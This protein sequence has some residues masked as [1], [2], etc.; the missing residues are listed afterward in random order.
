MKKVLL[1]LA[2]FLTMVFSACDDDTASNNSN[3]TN[4]TN[5]NN[6]N[7]TNNTNTNTN[8]TNNTNTNNTNNTNTNNINN[9]NNTNND[10]YVS[11]AS[12]WGPG[13]LEVEVMGFDA[14]TFGSNV[15]FTVYA[16]AFGGRY[17]VI[18]FQHGFMLD[19]TWFSSILGTIASHGFVVV[20]PQ[21]YGADNNPIGKPT[22]AEEAEQAYNFLQWVHLNLESELDVTISLDHVGYLGH[23]RG[24]KVSWILLDSCNDCAMAVAGIDPVDGTGGPMG[25]EARV[26]DGPFN[27]SF[28]SYV[29][30]TEFGTQSASMFSG[31]CAPE[32]DNYVQFYEASASPAFFS[33]ALGY[34]HLDFL[35]DLESCIICSTCVSAEGEHGPFRDFTA[36]QMVGF[37][38]GALSGD[39]A[40]YSDLEDSTSSPIEY[41]FESHF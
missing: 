40:S 19:A 30:G 5:T 14:D 15:D 26:I 37:F 18:I 29:M 7:N 34:G 38:R 21:M 12:I 28:P 1:S 35:D 25:G 13:G 33:L 32:G 27:F 24:G 41:D 2:M 11:D 4:N 6:I 22:A 23:S 31:A 39:T 20:A 16:P 9:T 17:P 8:N 10:I 36:A 3:N